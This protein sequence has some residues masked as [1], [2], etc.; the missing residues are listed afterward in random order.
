MAEVT[1]ETCLVQ[2]TLRG[3]QQDLDLSACPFTCT[4]SGE[5]A[6]VDYAS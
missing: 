1:E 5:S 2:V 4:P 6:E 3:V